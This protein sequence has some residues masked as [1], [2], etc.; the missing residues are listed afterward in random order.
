[1]YTSTG[2]FVWLCDLVF[3]V[4]ESMQT[5]GVSEEDVAGNIYT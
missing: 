2:C 3:H 5:E 4:K 1:M